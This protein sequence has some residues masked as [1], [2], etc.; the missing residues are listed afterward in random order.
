MKEFPLRVIDDLLYK[1]NKWLVLKKN[2]GKR[3]IGG[4]IGFSETHQKAL[5]RNARDK[6]FGFTNLF[7]D[8][9]KEYGE[10]ETKWV[11]VSAIRP[12]LD[13]LRNFTVQEYQTLG[14]ILRRNN[15]VFNKK[16]EQLIDKTNSK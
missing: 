5:L 14:E 4:C 11:N 8:M 1:S 13:V 16:K 15:F 12:K 6:F 10:D 2:I 3:Y 9:K 7:A